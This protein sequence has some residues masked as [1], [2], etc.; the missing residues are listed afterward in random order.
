MKRLTSLS[1]GL[2]VASFCAL[3][4]VKSANAQTLEFK[5]EKTEKYSIANLVNGISLENEGV[6]KN[7]I[8]FAGKYKVKKAANAIKEVL[9]YEKDYS[10]KL[11]MLNSL[12]RIDE[13]KAA[14]VAAEL[15]KNEND[16]RMKNVA[17]AFYLEYSNKAGNKIAAE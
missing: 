9:K 11:L 3:S 7:A 10:T 17:A 12:F 8:Y 6:R 14:A 5:S 15:Y 16:S 2:L 4:L 1:K 13:E